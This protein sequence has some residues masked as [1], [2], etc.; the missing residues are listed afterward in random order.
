MSSRLVHSLLIE[1]SVLFV[2]I[3]QLCFYLPVEHAVISTHGSSSGNSTLDTSYSQTERL[4]PEEPVPGPSGQDEVMPSPS[5]KLRISLIY[6]CTS[7]AAITTWITT[8][9]MVKYT[10]T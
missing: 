4:L 2:S 1:T 6:M 7:T 10:M 5:G 3:I 8:K 9:S